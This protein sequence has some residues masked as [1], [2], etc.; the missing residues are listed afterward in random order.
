[1]TYASL[2]EAWGWDRFAVD[3][4]E[5]GATSMIVADLPAGISAV[6]PTVYLI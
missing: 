1:M 3:A 6:I 4:A 2:L 5:A